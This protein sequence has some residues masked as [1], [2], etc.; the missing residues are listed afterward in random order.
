MEIESLLDE[1]KRILKE[2][3]CSEALGGHANL[4]T[5]VYHLIPGADGFKAEGNISDAQ[6]HH[7]LELL[8]Q[9]LEEECKVNPSL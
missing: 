3:N 9:R 8:S 4:G 2:K 1:R 7:R 6:E 5:E